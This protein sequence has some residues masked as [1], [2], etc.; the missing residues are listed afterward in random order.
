MGISGTLSSFLGTGKS[1][2]VST[3]LADPA[4]SFKEK[5][6]LESP[7]VW[8]VVGGVSHNLE[9]C[10]GEASDAVFGRGMIF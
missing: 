5:W 9:S 3:M 1:E 10:T 6:P 8:A 2:H 7:R 4:S